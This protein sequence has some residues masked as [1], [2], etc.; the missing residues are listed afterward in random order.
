[1]RLYKVYTREL[2]IYPVKLYWNCVYGSKE[3]R[4]KDPP[5]IKNIDELI[6]PQSHILKVES[7]KLG[8]Y[9]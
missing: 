5:D 1:M 6:G 8:K 7:E 9:G 4:F 3:A 2:G